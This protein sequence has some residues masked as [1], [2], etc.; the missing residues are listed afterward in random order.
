[1]LKTSNDQLR[2]DDWRI[3]FTRILPLHDLLDTARTVLPG[4]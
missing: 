3:L 4:T 2:P 1:M